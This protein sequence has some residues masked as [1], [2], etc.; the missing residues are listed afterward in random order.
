[1][2]LRG[3]FNTGGILVVVAAM[4]R[5]HPDSFY[6]V[7]VPS[8]G[9]RWGRASIAARTDPVA[10]A[11]PLG[12][13]LA[14]LDAMRAANV[15]KYLCERDWSEI[16]PVAVDDGARV[17]VFEIPRKE[18][19]ALAASLGGADRIERAIDIARLDPAG[20][21]LAD[22]VNVFTGGRA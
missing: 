12:E 20:R 11:L 14:T 3:L 22:G 2:N 15:A 18:L 16:V 13:A 17:G 7:I 19:D 10:I 9:A 1:M 4:R 5:T 8:A 6:A 21:A